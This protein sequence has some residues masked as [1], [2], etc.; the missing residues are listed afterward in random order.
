MA[1]GCPA[2]VGM[3]VDKE[4]GRQMNNFIHFITPEEAVKLGDERTLKEL[5]RAAKSK[6]RCEC[7]GEK[8]WKYAGTGLCFSC[9]TGES[10]ASEDYEL[11]EG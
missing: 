7:C 11:K 5:K 6:G 9:T 8:A 4:R 2:L 1:G 3:A 10:D